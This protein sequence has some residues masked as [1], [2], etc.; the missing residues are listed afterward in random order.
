MRQLGNFSMVFSTGKGPTQAV[1]CNGSLSV[2]HSTMKSVIKICFYFVNYIVSSY[3]IESLSDVRHA[4]D[5]GYSQ[6]W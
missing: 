5:T 2:V 6:H 4:D 1:S 3:H